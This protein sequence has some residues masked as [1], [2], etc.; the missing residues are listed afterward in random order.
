MLGGNKHEIEECINYSEIKSTKNNLKRLKLYG[1]PN[2]LEDT[3]FYLLL[4]VSKKTG[5]QILK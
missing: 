2:Q 3:K 4:E 1:E 5:E